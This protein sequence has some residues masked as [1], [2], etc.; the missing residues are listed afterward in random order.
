MDDDDDDD[1]EAAAAA[2]AA[3]C[4]VVGGSGGGVRCLLDFLD[5]KFI[6][7]PFF[8]ICCPQSDFI[9]FFTSSD[10][11]IDVV[12]CNDEG[13]VTI[14]LLLATIAVTNDVATTTLLLS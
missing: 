2:A 9:E 4:L 5:S 3:F 10:L 6:S 7:L 8:A 12:L 13:V 11:L 14:L 1:D